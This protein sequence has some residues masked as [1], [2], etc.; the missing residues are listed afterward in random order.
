MSAPAPSTN[1]TPILAV[2]SLRKVFAVRGAGS[3]GEVVAVKGA[4]FAVARGE[5]LAIVGESGSGKSTI[6]K[7]I[8]GLETPTAGEIV[9]DGSN[10]LTSS[11]RSRDRRRRGKLVQIVFQDPYTS[12]DRHQSVEKCL[13]EVVH[14]HFG[15]RGAEL[16][17][18]VSEL[19]DLV[20]LGEQQLR[21][22]ARTLS[23]GQRQRVAIAR[24]LAPAPKLL[25]LDEAVSALD[26]S[27]Q[28]QILN[29][30][31]DVRDETG[32]SYV[33]ITHNLAA[34]RQV[35]DRAIVMRQGEIVEEGKMA[36]ILDQPRDSYTRQLV[37][38]VP[39]PEW[40]PKA[41][42]IQ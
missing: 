31:C 5:A 28:A 19:G 33:F 13:G 14:F 35:A 3:A 29:L 12:L 20:G 2:T 39:R 22:R 4:S 18:R 1:D 40:Q 8:V 38:A 30:L 9:L 11:S 15:L 37:D 42:V 34:A 32:T 7:M 6:A 41:A 26:V 27:I 23:G 10:R 24:A 25:I 17:Q 21:S 16:R 36:E